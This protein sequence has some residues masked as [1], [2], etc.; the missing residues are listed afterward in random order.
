[1]AICWHFAHEYEY[2]LDDE[3][4]AVAIQSK[5]PESQVVR[6]SAMYE[7][8]GQQQCTWLRLGARDYDVCCIAQRR[9]S[10]LKLN[11]PWMETRHLVEDHVLDDAAVEGLRENAHR[12]IDA[13]RDW[14][15]PTCPA[16]CGQNRAHTLDAGCPCPW[17]ESL[18]ETRMC[19]P[20]FARRSDGSVQSTVPGLQILP[21][22]KS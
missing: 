21:P 10:Q 15:C 22:A 5:I 20:L 6:G 18:R 14:V 19:R 3:Q 16:C 13:L 1:M 17:K 7:S 4:L 2:D 8:G 12:Y 9:R 11:S